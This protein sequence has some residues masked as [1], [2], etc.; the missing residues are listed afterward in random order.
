MISVRRR[1]RP[2]RERPSVAPSVALSV[3]PSVAPFVAPSVAP[4]GSSLPPESEVSKQPN[5]TLGPKSSAAT[6]I[7]KYSENDL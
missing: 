3:A 7:P 1:R 5:G 6:S 2:R 4:S